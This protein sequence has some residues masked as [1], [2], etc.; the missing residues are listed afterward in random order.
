M[1][2]LAD[3]TCHKLGISMHR[4]PGLMLVTSK[5]VQLLGLKEIFL[6]ELE[7]AI[8]DSLGLNKAA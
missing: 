5:E 8:E 6:A 7:I 3:M 4:Q 2:R 1:V